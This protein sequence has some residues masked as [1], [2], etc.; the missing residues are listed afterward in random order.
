MKKKIYF[1][2]ILALFLG[3][4]SACNKTEEIDEHYGMIEV[5]YSDRTIWIKPKEN[6]IKNEFTEKDFTADEDRIRYIG[7]KY[8]ALYGIDVSGHQGSID[9][10]KVAADGVDFVYIRAG[11]RGYTYGDMF[12]DKSFYANIRGAAAAGLKVGVYFFSQAI[13]LVEVEEEAKFFLNIIDKYSPYIDL[14]VVYD[15]EAMDSPD[16]RTKFI[17]VARVTEFA[18]TFTARMKNAGYETGVYFNRHD[19]YMFDLARIQDNVMWFAGLESYPNFYYK[20]DMW[21]YSFSGRVD[22]IGPDVDLDI[23]FTPKK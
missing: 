8:D 9:W 17:D 21:Q 18:D 15:W 20:V 3:I 5:P 22:G 19:G 1:G 10:E 2:L 16:S 7:D 23:M 11:Y 12:V 6:A 4:F 13:N 14:P